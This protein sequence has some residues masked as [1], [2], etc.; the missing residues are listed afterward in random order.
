MF[1]EICGFILNIFMITTVFAVI[2]ISL[3]ILY[4]EDR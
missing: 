3:V 2:P 4:L 1:N